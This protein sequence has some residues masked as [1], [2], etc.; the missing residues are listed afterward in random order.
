MNDRNVS[1]ETAPAYYKSKLWRRLARFYDPLIKLVFLPCGG[2][3]RF[4]KRCLDF[5]ALSE[6]DR[7]LDLCCGTG[8]LTHL[9]AERIGASGQV[10]GLDLSPAMLERARQKSKKG[11]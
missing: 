10:I 8:T 2:E 6:G 7:V 9:I 4:R 1:K 3:K 5:A 11:A